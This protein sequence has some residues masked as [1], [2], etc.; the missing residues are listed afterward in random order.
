MESIVLEQIVRPFCE[1]VYSPVIFT[2]SLSVERWFIT[3]DLHLSRSLSLS[4]H[5]FIWR[6]KPAS[7]F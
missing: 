4:F 1:Q 5:L 2:V 6:F 7:D 3:N